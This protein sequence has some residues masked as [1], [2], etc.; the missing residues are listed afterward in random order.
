MPQLLE[1]YTKTKVFNN[2]A[3]P[4][5]DRIKSYINVNKIIIKHLIKMY[6]PGMSTYKNH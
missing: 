4:V 1:T 2:S 3:W 5:Q 6:K